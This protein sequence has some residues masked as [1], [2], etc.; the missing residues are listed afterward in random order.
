[1]GQSSQPARKSLWFFIV[2]VNV[3]LVAKT[4]VVLFR[5]QRTSGISADDA[6]TGELLA[7][8]EKHDSEGTFLK[9]NEIRTQFRLFL[10]FCFLFLLRFGQ[11]EPLTLLIPL[12]ISRV[13]ILPVKSSFSCSIVLTMIEYSSSKS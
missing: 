13:F 6:E 3:A 4:T 1:M 7:G 8:G 2:I 5:R 11:V 9:E 10:F 12:K